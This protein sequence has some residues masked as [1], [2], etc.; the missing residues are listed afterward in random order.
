M[1]YNNSVILLADKLSIGLFLVKSVQESLVI[2]PQ[3]EAV[4]GLQNLELMPL[5]DEAVLE[6]RR[7]EPVLFGLK[8]HLA[9]DGQLYLS[10]DK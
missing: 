4:L 10:R 6:G 1:V 8:E 5:H 2:D 7:V 9:I 3:L